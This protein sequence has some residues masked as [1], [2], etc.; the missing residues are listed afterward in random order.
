VV[1][2][3]TTNGTVPGTRTRYD[4]GDLE[5]EIE[6]WLQRDVSGGNE[7]RTFRSWQAAPADEAACFA[8][9]PG[10]LAGSVYTVNSTELRA[11]GFELEPVAPVGGAPLGVVARVRRTAAVTGE[12]RRLR[13][14]TTAV[15]AELA[16]PP[17]RALWTISS[18]DENIILGRCW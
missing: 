8:A 6:P 5:I 9:D 1:K 3:H 10:P 12:A 11:V 16:A 2:E 7:R 17:L 13:G 15:H 18:A 4:V 14:V